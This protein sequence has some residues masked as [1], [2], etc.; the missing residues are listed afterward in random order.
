MILDSR[1]EQGRVLTSIDQFHEMRHFRVT[2]LAV[3]LVFVDCE[4]CFHH[5][6]QLVETHARFPLPAVRLDGPIGSDLT[7]SFPK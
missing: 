2:I 4:D 7:C 5:R 1:Q 6:D 3:D